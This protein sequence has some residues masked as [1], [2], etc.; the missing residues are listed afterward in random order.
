MNHDAAIPVEEVAKQLAPQ[1]R[2]RCYPDYRDS[3]IEW[4][5]ELPAHW[6]ARR[7]KF[8]ARTVTG[9]TPPKGNADNYDSEGTPWVKP[10]DLGAFTPIM[11]S[12]E[13][14]SETGEAGT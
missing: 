8:V 12:K 2:F 14:L 7:L 6:E 3:G 13:R 9:N 11:E 10:D 1:R 5:G 4:L